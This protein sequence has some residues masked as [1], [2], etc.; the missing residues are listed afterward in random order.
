[1]PRTMEMLTNDLVSNIMGEVK[2]LSTEKITAPNP[3]EM[4]MKDDEC[5][6]GDSN[7][8]VKL[9][10]T[11]YLEFEE[12]ILQ[13]SSLQF[14][15]LKVLG[16]FL[17]SNSFNELMQNEARSTTKLK[18][19]MHCLV[20]KSVEQ[21]KL[22]HILTTNEIERAQSI[23]YLNHT[24]DRSTNN[25][26]IQNSDDDSYE[27]DT[28]ETFINEPSTSQQLSQ[29]S[30]YR[31]TD[32]IRPPSSLL[33]SSPSCSRNDLRRRISPAIAAPLLEMGFPLKHILNAMFETHGMGEVNSTNINMLATWMLEHPYTETNEQAVPNSGTSDAILTA[34]NEL[35]TSVET[36]S[37]RIR[38]LLD[39]SQDLLIGLTLN[40]MRVS[41]TANECREEADE[42]DEEVQTSCNEI[43]TK[44]GQ[45]VASAIL[46]VIF[47]ESPLIERDM[48]H[49]KLSV[50]EYGEDFDKVKSY[51]GGAEKEFQVKAINFESIDPLGVDSV[52]KVCTGAKGKVESTA[53]CIGIQMSQLKTAVERIDALKYLT[54]TM[55]VLLSR[56][57][58]L[59]VL[60]LLSSSTNYIKLVECLEMIGLSDIRKVVRLMTLIAMNRIEIGNIHLGDEMPLK[61][62]VL[63][64]VSSSAN[65]CLNY[66]SIG[67]AALAQ[68]QLEKSN[69]V[70]EM[71]TK[72]LMMSAFGVYL[73]IAG[74]TVTQ[75]L[76]N[77]LA[78]HGGT[79]LMDKEEVTAPLSPVPVTTG[80]LTLVNALSAY[81]LSSHIENGQR[82]WAVQQLYR[83]IGTKVQLN[84]AASN[85]QVNLADLSQF[86]PKQNV[87]L[88]EAHENP[89]ASLAIHNKMQLLGTAGYDGTVRLWLVEPKKQPTLDSTLVFHI[90]LN[91][92]GSE[93]K[94]RL[95]QHL[96]FS[97]NGEYIAACM[98]NFL[99]I[100]PLK[101]TVECDWFIDDQK[102]FVTVIQ[103]PRNCSDSCEGVPT[104][105]SRKNYLLV[106][107]IDGSVALITICNGK[108]QVETLMN[109]TLSHGMNCN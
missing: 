98:D 19:I 34:A 108:K 48:H 1:M 96:K 10:E 76:V 37:S 107:K 93:L 16:I 58:I 78:M 51:L 15:A 83:L 32:I 64:S 95:I 68:N 81:L 63:T 23:L 47:D 90:S 2:R 54:K 59:Q 70:I 62:N 65:V 103:W 101:K 20:E 7:R 72:D 88:L 79:I 39:R 50:P 18:E 38:L 89:V 49:V 41:E 14:S 22:K 9:L 36:V 28:N 8:E 30:K 61:T 73:P 26:D 27:L 29:Q 11:K 33:L 100:W 35:E 82:E 109:F 3:N 106:G 66:L 69:L 21:C 4:N 44:S 40:S 57:I 55:H 60:S 75:S 43:K 87:S 97:P 74:F 99:N 6:A 56:S 86:L 77:I 42:S 46:D 25:D 31:L 52:Q 85:E 17:T 45:N 13:L 92:F 12:R 91:V 104:D 24:K 71:C 94:N 80:P 102:E 84:G 53:K 5:K 105:G 67:I